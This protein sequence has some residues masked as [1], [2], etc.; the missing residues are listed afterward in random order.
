MRYR[1]NRP[2]VMW[3]GTSSVLARRTISEGFI[4][5]PRRKRWSEGYMESFPGTYLTSNWMTAY[6][7]AG[8]AVDKFGGNRVIF[9]VIAELR[10]TLPDEDHLPQAAHALARANK[11]AMLGPY[12]AERIVSD[13]KYAEGFVENGVDEYLA[14]MDMRFQSKRMDARH[15]RMLRPY[16]RRY[17]WATLQAAADLQTTMKY[18]AP[19]EYGESRHETPRV[20]AAR[21]LLIDRLRGISNYIPHDDFM[22]GLHNVRID[23]PVRFRGANRILSAVEIVQP[24]KIHPYRSASSPENPYVL[25]PLMGTIP[26]DFLDAFNRHIGGVVEIGA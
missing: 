13:P 4:P 16:I 12:L 1:R 20:R 22:V 7:A 8:N 2:E 17:L 19:Y 9:K 15:R 10:T 6:S 14:D 26:K 23:R 11:L 3:H 18:D 21:A 25:I 24:R 5:S